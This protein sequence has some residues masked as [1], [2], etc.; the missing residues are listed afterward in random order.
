MPS[1]EANGRVRAAE[2]IVRQ[3]E[4]LTVDE[5][6][7]LQE[8]KDYKQLD[9]EFTKNKCLTDFWT[10]VQY[11]ARYPMAHYSG[12]LHGVTANK[13]P[14]P[15][16]HGMAHFLTHWT[17]ERDGMTIPVQLKVVEVSREHC[18][19]QLGPIA[20][21]AWTIGRDPDIC[22]ALRS[23]VSPKGEEILTGL[24]GLLRKPS[25][26]A[27]FPWVKPLVINKR[28]VQWRAD[29]IIVERVNTEIRTS[30][31]EVGGVEKDFTGAHYHVFMYDDYETEDSANSI[32]ERDKLDNRFRMDVNLATGGTKRI[33]WGTPYHIKAIMNQALRGKG[34]FEDV[35][36]DLFV[37]ACMYKATEN[38]IRV[39]SPALSDDRC[40]IW[41]QDSEFA[42]PDLALHQAKAE[43]YSEEQKDVIT[44]IREVVASSHEHIE[45]NRPFPEKLGKPLSV[46]VDQFKP[47]LPEKFT[48]DHYD[49]FPNNYEDTGVARTSLVMRK[50]DLGSHIF[51]AQMMMNPL[52]P[53]NCLFRRDQI[54]KVKMEDV[55]RENVLAY[56]TCDLAGS[57]PTG[58]KTCALTS[59]HHS[60]GIYMVHIFLGFKTKTE[61]LWE[62]FVRMKWLK[63]T[64]G[65]EYKWTSL[66]EAARE[67]FLRADL[68]IAQRDPFSYFVNLGDYKIQAER[69][70][71]PGQRMNIPTILVPR[72]GWASK[73][74]RIG[75]T[76]PTVEAKEVFIVE[77]IEHSEEALDAF[78]MYN[79]AQGK[80]NEGLDFL[81]CF[82][83]A[84]REGRV[85][86]EHQ[87]KPHKP[88]RDFLER[89]K[90]AMMATGAHKLAKG[91]WS[92]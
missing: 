88:G 37:A 8:R 38:V 10:F 31:V 35:I 55:P 51:Q 6:R 54:R 45:V 14:Y 80:N 79:P 28:T 52:D 71:E 24:K 61:T 65:L 63:D 23:H 53:E 21:G 69:Y 76:Q 29:Q 89:Q 44:Q 2:E 87:E 90:R 86:R 26:T 3:F 58:A 85:P 18:K 15:V 36:Y 57:A 11:G 74:T 43:F 30:T 5:H 16:A 48:L 62:L 46:V 19:T 32:T 39:E 13:P 41:V 50:V 70:F 25:Y 27:V 81:D 77:G 22:M 73:E 67:E 33:M 92:V 47:T 7:R 91:S 66:E 60:T 17:V 78:E 59:I 42:G 34:V 20:Y 9:W 12:A 1:D 4:S 49:V 40:T 64:Y 68:K 84:V 82:A 56:R 83:D 75:S 72:G